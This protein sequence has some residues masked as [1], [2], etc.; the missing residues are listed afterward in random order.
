MTLLIVAFMILF[1]IAAD[2]ID[3][4]LRRIGAALDRIAEQRERP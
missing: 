3:N 2:S 1:Y 4:R